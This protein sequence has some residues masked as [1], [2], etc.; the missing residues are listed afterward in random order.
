[1]DLEMKIFDVLK[2]R[3]LTLY[4]NYNLTNDTFALD[5]WSYMK[6]SMY[7]KILEFQKIDFKMVFLG[8][9]VNF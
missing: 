9:N 3:A 4:Q 5:E 7:S 2:I 6:A 1:M 8:F